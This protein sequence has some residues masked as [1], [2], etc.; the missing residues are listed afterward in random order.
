MIKNNGRG[1]F[2]TAYFIVLAGTGP[3]TGG[4]RFRK[5]GVG[6]FGARFRPRTR[7][8]YKTGLDPFP[9]TGSGPFRDPFWKLRL[10]VFKAVPGIGGKHSRKRPA[11]R[12]ENGTQPVLAAVFK[13]FER[14]L[15]FFI[16]AVFQFQCDQR[17]GSA[18]L[19]GSPARF[20][21]RFDHVWNHHINSQALVSRTLGLYIKGTQQAQILGIILEKYHEL[22]HY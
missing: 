4:T 9:K 20:N 21:R 14:N 12:F 16:V 7:T 3:E 15:L 8:A 13:L 18:V 19:S 17:K 11:A 2:Q 1:R 22:S 5:R 10:L 6:R